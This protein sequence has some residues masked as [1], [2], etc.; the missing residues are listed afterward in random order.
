MAVREFALPDLGE[1]LTESELVAWKVAVGDTVQLNQIIAEVETAKALVELPAPYDGRVSR[2]FVEPGVT[3]AVGEPLVAFEV[4]AGEPEGDALAAPAAPASETAPAASPDGREPTLVGYGARPESGARPARRARPGLAVAGSAAAGAGSV[5]TAQTAVTTVA[6]TASAASP[7]PNT[8]ATATA[9]AERPR[10]TPPVRKFARELGVDL[11]SVAGSGDRGLITRGDVQ[12]YAEQRGSGS[13]TAA[14]AATVD[15]G[16][17]E[18]RIPIR[19]VRKAT[20]DA[21]VRSAFGAPQA[22]V[23]LTIDVTPTME[24]ISRLRALPELAEARPGLLAVVAKALLLAVR[25][26][27][28]VN[29]RWDD[30]ANEIVQAEYVHLGIAAA[31]PRGLMVPVIRD[32]DGMTLGGLS[33]AIRSLAET[34]RAGRTAPADL[35]GGTITITNVGVFGVDAGTP[36]LTPGEAAILAVGAVRRQPWEH[37]GG[38]ALRQVLT[39]ALTFDHRIV[40]GEQA[41]RFLADI[42]R[43]LAD[44]A[45]VLTL[46]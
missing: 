18:K 35:S 31:T 39:L 21:M 3:V 12:Q 43:I 10:A 37:D 44:P 42:G 6:A 19:G 26:T 15:A 28:E 4:D 11:A 30:A 22:T 46:V 17:R 34:A 41:S 33:G 45:S 7:A 8:G 40:D 9:L 2:L 38:I 36:I 20:A 25:R 16:A 1:G 32:A 14:G 13:A 27:P 23:F 5:A 24:L 29:S